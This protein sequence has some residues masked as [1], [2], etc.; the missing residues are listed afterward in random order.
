[1]ISFFDAHDIV[2]LK[3]QSVHCKSS[4]DLT[5]VDLTLTND[6]CKFQSTFFIERYQRTFRFSFKFCTDVYLTKDLFVT[7][8]FD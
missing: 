7:N 8:N 3:K 4:Q 1:M 5:S 6:S 2:S